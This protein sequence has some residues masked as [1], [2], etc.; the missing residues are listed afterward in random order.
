MKIPFTSVACVVVLLAGCV[1]A[2]EGGTPSGSATAAPAQASAASQRIN[3]RERVTLDVGES[4]VVHGLRGE[5]GSLPTAQRVAQA[6]ADL[7]AQTNL[8]TFSFGAEGV[9]RSGSCNGNTPAFQTIF[10]A[11]NPGRQTVR[12]HGDSVQITVR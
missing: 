8:G 11:T 10:T 9:R 12:V 3:Y 2:G 5:C 4:A 6:T 1:P 7:N